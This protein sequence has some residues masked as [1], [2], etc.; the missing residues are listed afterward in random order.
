MDEKVIIETDSAPA[1]VGPYSQAVKYGNTLFLA[2]QIGLDPGTGQMVGPDTA[3]QIAAIFKSAQAILEYAG[4]N[5]GNIVR[6][7]VYLLDVNEMNVVNQ[8]FQEH[9]AYQPPA[10]TTVQVAA[11]PAGARIEIEITAVFHPSSGLS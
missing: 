4:L 8:A 11:L 7:V 5:M 3:S 10:R 2:G 6:C 9:F 1:P